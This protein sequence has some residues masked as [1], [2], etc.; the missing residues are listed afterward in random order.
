[1]GSGAMS[2]CHFI[3]PMAVMLVLM[4]A[5]ATVAAE[6]RNRTSDIEQIGTALAPPR[7]EATVAPSAMAVGMVPE[8]NTARITQHGTGHQA[9]VRQ[10]GNSL[11]ATVEQSGT[12]GSASVD[13]SGIGL[14]ARVEQFGAS[15][16]VQVL[17]SGVGNG[18][19]VSVQQ[20]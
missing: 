6:Q 18:A 9:E 7:D 10:Q 19:T 4:S 2:P 8:G 17:Q 13:Q 16:G 20:Y 11:E 5:M 3:P 1:M 15:N 14:N 12:G